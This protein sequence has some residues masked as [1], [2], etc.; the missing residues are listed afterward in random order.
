M[1]DGKI[2]G[3]DPDMVRWLVSTARELNPIAT[4]T[5]AGDQSAVGLEAEL[6]AIQNLR[7]TDNRK[8]Y[9]DKVQ[10]RELELMDAQAKHQAQ[11]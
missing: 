4:V 7:K 8:Y 6:E 10:A 11:A 1:A 5:E 2:V 3:D 9:S